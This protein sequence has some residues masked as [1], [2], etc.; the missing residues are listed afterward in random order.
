M[1]GLAI[2]TI[3]ENDVMLAHDK[4]DVGDN[5]ERVFVGI[6]LLNRL[7]LLERC[8]GAIDYPAEIVVVNNNAIDVTFGND[9]DHLARHHG[10]EILHQD[11]NLGVAASWNLVIRTA[12]DRGRDWVFIGS[13]DTM[14]HAGSLKATVELPKAGNI[15]IWHL[16]AFNFFLI[17]RPCVERVGWFDENFYPAYKEDQDYSYRCELAQLGRVDVDGAGG[18]HVGS[19]TIRSDPEY[20]RLN[21]D[22]HCNWNANHYRMKWGGDAGNEVYRHPYNNPEYDHTWWPDPGGSVEHRDWDKRRRR[23]LVNKTRPT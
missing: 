14:L 7:D 4:T 9:L 8:V 5:A 13:N 11:R 2:A 10:L 6:P 21:A 18:D 23:Q 17:N 15:A 20:A 3:E 19:A 12:L 16:L 22:T 1:A